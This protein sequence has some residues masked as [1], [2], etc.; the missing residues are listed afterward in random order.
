MTN[1]LLK[2]YKQAARREVRAYMNQH[3]YA[4]FIAKLLKTKSRFMPQFV[5]IFL[6]KLIIKTRDEYYAA[7]A[8][9]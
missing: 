8:G 5:W 9:Q 4:G 1:K 2:K 7:Q 6:V 3:E